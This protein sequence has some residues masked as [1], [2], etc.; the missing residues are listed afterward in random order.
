MSLL[1]YFTNKI[2]SCNCQGERFLT[3]FQV[4]LEKCHF[5][6]YCSFMLNLK[7]KN[8]FVVNWCE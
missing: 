8:K 4:Q 3:V 1:F 2:E 5:Q 7:K 6:R